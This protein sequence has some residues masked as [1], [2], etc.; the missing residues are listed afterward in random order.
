M[1]EKLLLKGGTVYTMA[2]PPAKGDVLIADGKIAAVGPAIDDPEARLIDAGGMHVMPGLVDAHCHTGLLTSGTRDRN[3]NESSEPICPQMR[4]IDSIDPTDCAFAE[5]LTGGV[6]SCLTGPGSIELIG[7]TFAAVKTYGAT[8]EDMLI[9]PAAAMKAALGENPI[10]YFSQKNKAPF[11]RM[12]AAA[13]IRQAL[14]S[15]ADY[16]PGSGKRDLAMEALR[17][18]IERKI[19]LKIHCHRMNDIMTAIRICDEFN[20]LYTLDHCTEGYLITDKLAAALEKNCV[21]LIIGPLKGYKSKHELMRRIG[22]DLAVKLDAAGLPFA[23][24]TDFYEQPTESL[25]T[26]AAFI[27]AAGVPDDTA[28]K[29]VTSTAAKIAG[30]SDRVGSIAPGLDAD[31]AVFSGYPLEIRS[32]C[33]MTLVDGKIVYR[34]ND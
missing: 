5:A 31:I 22:W 2:A 4:A 16:V 20:V 1:K 11:S 13:M 29:S 30:L 17:P 15:A 12:G 28:L 3:H 24:M 21:G 33:V 34:K 27:A 26:N 19:P 8:V 6:T 23:V 10:N 9:E 7:G 14:A 32:V 25:I 18:V